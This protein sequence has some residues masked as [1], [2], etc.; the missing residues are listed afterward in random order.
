MNWRL[1]L[2]I[3]IFALMMNKIAPLRILIIDDDVLSREVLT[4]LL[5]HAGYIVQAVDS[6][7][8]ATRSLQSAEEPFPDVILADMQMPGISGKALARE[9]RERCGTSTKVLAISGS[10]P[11]DEA[12]REFDG[13]LLKPF[14]I[15]ELTAAI[16]TNGITAEV[17]NGAVSRNQASLDEAIYQKLQGS[18][19]SERLEQLYTL[20]LGDIE[21]RV[22][23]MQKAASNKDDAA[24]RKEAHA[25][26][27]GCGMVGAVELQA[28]AAS[29]EE[30]GIEANHVASLNELILASQ[31]LRRILMARR[32]DGRPRPDG[33]KRAQ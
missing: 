27:G 13:L 16:T 12:I 4:L 19:R 2:A 1:N 10:V 8:A 7:D 31:R 3:D 14:T 29:M 33:G 24:Y 26:R 18:M 22:A 17:S 23:R 9:L 30:K 20:S 21:E 6:G 11:D 32:V 15:N 25:I 5:E 28:L